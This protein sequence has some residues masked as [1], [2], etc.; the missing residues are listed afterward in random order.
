M[1]QWSILGVALVTAAMVAANGCGGG[2]KDDALGTVPVPSGGGGAAGAGS[3]DGGG[4]GASGADGGSASPIL[5][6]EAVAPESYV[7]KVKNLLTGLPAT[8][9]ELTA[10][11]K[12][13]TALAG[14]ID[15]WLALPSADTKLIDFF[16]DAFQQTQMTADDFSDEIGDMT[17]APAALMPNLQESFARTAL[18]IMKAGTPFNQTVTT[19]SFMM[20]TALLQFYSFLD[21]RLR[22]DDDYDLDK[23]SPPR[24]ADFVWTATDDTVHHVD[25]ADSLNPAS[26]DYLTWSVGPESA[27]GPVGSQCVPRTFHSAQYS[28]ASVHLFLLQYGTLGTAPVT[29]AGCPNSYAITGLTPILTASD[30]TDWRMV[31]VQRSS[32]TNP[33]NINLFYNV[34]A[35]RKA[36]SIVLDV[37]RVGFFSTPSFFANWATNVNNQARVTTNQS[38]ITALGQSINPETVTIP[39]SESGLDTQHADPTTVCYTCHKVLDPMRE[40]FRSTYSLPYHEQTDTTEQADVASFDFAGVDAVS[41]MNGVTNGIDSFAATLAAHPFFAGAW[42]QK[43]CVWADSAACDAQDPEFL[44][45]VAAFQASNLDFRVLVRELLSSPLVTAASS[46][47]TFTT[48][49]PIVSIAR[50]DHY[51][52]ALS[53]RLGIDACN[54]PTA[55]AQVSS[56]AQLLSGNLPADGYARGAEIPNLVSAP[57]LFHRSTVENL[58]GDIATVIIDAPGGKYTSAA[59]D[60]AIADLVANVMGL[61]SADDRA[62][63]IT[64]VLQGHYTAAI[65]AGATPTE[66]LDST[67][68]LACTSPLATAIGL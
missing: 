31:T 17:A 4:A 59:K 63:A 56:S 16:G 28:D 54:L 13:P 11:Q 44:R 51:C 64:A 30:F 65:A 38:L 37:P 68:T 3:G 52:T 45:V 10:V 67:F 29:P 14:L 55:R 19:S 21:E 27:L 58:C 41:G 23:L 35:L 8:A 43:L 6:F 5:P 61:S 18:A 15:Q 32:P 26:P 33:S 53:V 57:G 42:A 62:T 60:A 39:L 34:P 40:F 25:L 49:E 22:N 7:A 46:T 9:A 48:R 66:A 1:R 2:T 20:T 24:T 50:Q 47:E 12:D 36:T